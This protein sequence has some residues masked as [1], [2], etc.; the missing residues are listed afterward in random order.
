MQFLLAIFKPCFIG[1]LSNQYTVAA[2]DVAKCNIE[3]FIPFSDCGKQ[4]YRR[5]IVS[6]ER[7]FEDVISLN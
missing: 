1:K 2:L 7:I 3:S 6:N 4:N 5:E